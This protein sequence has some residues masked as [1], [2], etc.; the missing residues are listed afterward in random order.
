[1]ASAAVAKDQSSEKRSVK[2][3]TGRLRTNQVNLKAP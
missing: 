3:R 1:M 2:I